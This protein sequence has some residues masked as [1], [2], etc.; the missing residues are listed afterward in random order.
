M[1]FLLFL[2]ILIFSVYK[3]IS[4]VFALLAG[5]VLFSFLALRKG[6]S[7]N[8]IKSFATEGIKS[9]FIVIKIMCIIGVLTAIWRISDTIS[10]FCYYGLKFITPHFFIL[11]AFLL[12]CLLSYAIGTSFGVAAT[13]GVVMVSIAGAGGVSTAITAGA[14]M[15]GV[16]FGD[17]MSPV[18]SSANMIAAVTH[19]EI[20]TNVSYMM[21]TGAVPFFLS[22][23]LY[24]AVSF[25]HPLSYVD[26][27]VI[28]SF[29]TDSLA[30]FI[31]AVLVMVLPLLKVP[32]VN[33]MLFSI[34][35]GILVVLFNGSYSFSEILKISVFGLHQSGNLDGGGL[36]SIVELILIIVIS[37]SYSGI[38]KATDMLSYLQEKITQGCKKAGSFT[39][40]LIICILSAMMFCSQTIVILTGKMLLE[41]SY[42][43]L[44]LTK[45]DLAIDIENSAIFISALVPWNICCYMP[46]LFMN[47]DA[48]SLPY[49]FFLYLLPIWWLIR[50][51][52]KKNRSLCRE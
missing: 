35:S 17:R 29:R 10:I 46:L 32:V 13:V 48:S 26:T 3:G 51:G 33:A 40:L 9:S 42:E 27:S 7:L 37:S 25:Y 16:F 23:I 19:T 39:I 24:A 6:Y 34:A 36:F 21:K 38:F 14:V 12:S 44:S 52:L 2:F 43:K 1:T 31:P 15:S 41:D 8:Q 50:R 30:G 49:A 22:V 47:A 4:I 28:E 45:E 20:Y 5:L 18:S 11:L